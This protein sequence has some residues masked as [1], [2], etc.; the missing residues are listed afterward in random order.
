MLSPAPFVLSKDDIKLADERAIRVL[1]PAN[2]DWRPRAI[3]GKSSGMKSH[4]FKQIATN[5]ILTFCLRNMLGKKQR[6]TLFLL[7]NTLS[8][9]CAEEV[10]VDGIDS[11][12]KVVHETLAC[13]E[14]DFPLSVNVISL[15]LVHHLPLFI[16]RFG[17]LYSFW[18]FPFERLNSWLH[19]RILNRQYPESCIIETYCLSEWAHFMQ[20]TGQLPHKSITDILGEPDDDITETIPGC[21]DIKLSSEQL[22]QLCSHYRQVFEEYDD[23]WRWYENDT[24]HTQS[25]RRIPMSEWAM[26]NNS[27]LTDLQ[28]MCQQ[29]SSKCIATRIKHKGYDC[30]HRSIMFSSADADREISY[31]RN[32]FV[33][34]RNAGVTKVGRIMSI[35]RHKFVS[36]LFCFCILV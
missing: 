6:Q 19:R 36:T 14:R 17:P 15:H 32:S 13:I 26:C 34:L 4:E 18:M 20:L 7:F 27:L 3:F 8:K 11:L 16:R 35:F 10:S 30:H 2:F 23:L 24:S 9:L 5:G 28:Q 21:K 29:L 12:E 33:S 1:V 25:Q 31:T 22:I